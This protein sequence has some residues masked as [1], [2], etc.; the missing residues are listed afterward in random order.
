VFFL[1]R[2]PQNEAYQNFADQRALLGIPNC[3]NVISNI[4][5]FIVGTWGIV[6]VFSTGAA[7]RATLADGRERWPYFVFFTGVALA[8]FGSA[9]Y[10][11]RP[12]HGRLVWTVFP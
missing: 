1:P 2:I 11:L 7:S 3:L 6:A 4:P 9:Y 5:F 8:A 12:G 10:H